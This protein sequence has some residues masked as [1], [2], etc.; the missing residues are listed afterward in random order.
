M[1]ELGGRI[2]GSEVNRN[3]TGQLI[4]STNLDPWELW[5]LQ[6]PTSMHG[7]AWAPDTNVAAV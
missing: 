1:E 6:Q 5:Q 3:S 4:E 7:L 2:E